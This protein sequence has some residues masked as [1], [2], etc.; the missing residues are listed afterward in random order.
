MC[1]L[2]AP[3]SGTA[4]VMRTGVL[5]VWWHTRCARYTDA[6]VFKLVFDD[7]IVSIHA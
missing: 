2:S 7:A 6:Y 1:T 4:R 5:G 3:V